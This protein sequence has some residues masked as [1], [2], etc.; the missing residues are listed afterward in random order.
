MELYG[1]TKQKQAQGKGLGNRKY[2]VKKN[3]RVIGVPNGAYYLTYRLALRKYRAIARFMRFKFVP[4]GFN[5]INFSATGQ[6]NT[7]L[8]DGRPYL[9]PSILI[10]VAESGVKRE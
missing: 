7:F 4:N 9:Y 1:Y 2:R 6:R 3:N 10:R 5:G 8:K